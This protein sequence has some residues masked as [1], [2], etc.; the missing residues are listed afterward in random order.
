MIIEVTQEDINKGIPRQCALCPVAL[1][2]KRASGRELQVTK[3]KILMFS[4]ISGEKAQWIQLPEKVVDFIQ[5]YDTTRKKLKPFS[6]ELEI[7]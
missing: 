7:D 4:N 3:N 1:A 6:F 2:T 5:V